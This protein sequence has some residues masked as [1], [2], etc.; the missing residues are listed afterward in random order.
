MI[1]DAAYSKRD[2]VGNP[3]LRCGA[4]AENP[5]VW[6]GSGTTCGITDALNLRVSTQSDMSDFSTNWSQPFT[7]DHTYTFGEEITLTQAGKIYFT[8]FDDYYGDNQG[9]IDV[10]II[11]VADATTQ[12]TDQTGCTVFEDVPFGTY[13]L[14]EEM[15]E[16]WTVV[17]D[18]TTDGS[19]T[20]GEEEPTEYRFVNEQVQNP[21]APQAADITVCKDEQIDGVV[22]PYTTGW[23]MTLGGSESESLVQELTLDATNP[24][25]EQTQVLDAGTQYRIEVEGTWFNGNRSVDAEYYSD[26]AWST[27]E[28]MEDDTSRDLRQLDV[29][30]NDANVNWGTYD[31]GHNYETIVEGTDAALDMRIYDEDG[32]PTNFAWYQDNDGQLT[33][34]IFE[35]ST[36]EATTQT[37]DETGCTVFEGVPYGT[38][39]LTEETKEGWTVVTDPTT[40]GSITVGEEEPTEYR[41]V[42]EQ[43]QTEQPEP[44]PQPEE[45]VGQ[46]TIQKA[47]NVQPNPVQAGATVTYTIQVTAEDDP[48]NDV[49]VLDLPPEGFSYVKGSWTAQSNERGDLKDSGVTTE[50]T[51]ASPGTWELGD[52]EAGEVVTLTYET[53]IANN[54]EDGLYTDLAWA[55]GDGADALTGTTVTDQSLANGTNSSYVDGE[56]VGTEVLIASDRITEA[57]SVDVVTEETREEESSDSQG[58]VLG[59]TT[60]LPETGAR[61]IWMV[62]A[63]LLTG[64]GILMLGTG[65]T[66]RNR[67]KERHF[68]SLFR[69]S[70]R[71]ITAGAVV[72]TVMFMMQTGVHAADT[73]IRISAPE[74]RLNTNTFK[75]AFVT[76]N[77]ENEPVT[78]QCE[79]R[80]PTDTDYTPFGAAVTTA[81]GGDSGFCQ[82]NQSVVGEN[83]ASY[84][85]RATAAVDGV[86]VAQS[87][88][89]GTSYDDTDPDR[90]TGY[91]KS[92]ADSCT[93]EITVTAANDEGESERLELYRA[94]QTN[95]TIEPATR[96]AVRPVNSG[97]QVTFTDVIPDC[98]QKYY[99]AVRAYDSFGNGSDVVADREVSVTV[100]TVSTGGGTTGGGTTEG[101]ATA[102]DT[103]AAAGAILVEGGGDVAGADT[104]GGAGD[105]AEGEVA[106][107]QTGGEE[108]NEEATSD[109]ED[110]N[111]TNDS[112]EAVLGEQTEN[113]TDEEGMGSMPWYIL[114]GAL[115]V[116]GMLLIYRFYGRKA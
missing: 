81:P 91:S 86:I 27:V 113:G 50:P 67:D 102:G 9:G 109:E 63:G 51:Y 52:L 11:K 99:Y 34:R 48:I 87:N 3:L 96:I 39:T 72:T 68:R 69:T 115:V 60:S 10:E 73:S 31:E 16:G 45:P 57:A 75:I 97:E 90:P 71:V 112:G 53:T 114:G 106:G 12:T 25:P 110:E 37:T 103:G 77:Y 89:I 22:A 116:I 62:I 17:T 36:T 84:S 61:T 111:E 41:F 54:Q 74:E 42:N 56:F 38:Y 107:E 85:F 14:T 46:L 58:D 6:M 44:E 13:T 29:V 5:W 49:Q 66:M 94:A 24:N 92:K 20:V 108:E 70:M 19:I 1:A 23:D 93:Y 100:S 82:V 59:A 47:N 95:F 21:E 98:G 64:T 28:D 83:G 65:I 78:V 101:T 35:I 55:K 15:K 26:D 88:Q 40:D 30:I 79:K 32:D 2:T 8:I 105:D 33:V 104:G 7:S 18:P 80:G 43:D 4:D 76:L